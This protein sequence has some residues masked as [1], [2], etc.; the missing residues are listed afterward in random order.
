MRMQAEESANH[1]LTLYDVACNLWA[2]YLLLWYL[3]GSSHLSKGENFELGHYFQGEV[4][5]ESR[6]SGS[7]EYFVVFLRVVEW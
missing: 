1:H 6:E 7:L 2:S 4:Q 3:M 5:T